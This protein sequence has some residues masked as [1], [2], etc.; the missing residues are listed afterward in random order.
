ML[1]F[2]PHSHLWIFLLRAK[3]L[4]EEEEDEKEE[5]EEEEKEEE[6]K[7]EGQMKLH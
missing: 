7:E 4:K 3:N 1:V 2:N 6:R 5:E